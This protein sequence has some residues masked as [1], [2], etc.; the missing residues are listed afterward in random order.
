MRMFRKS[1]IVFSA[2]ASL[3]AMMA[4]AL[5]Q[6]GARREQGV[7]RA[8]ENQQDRIGQGVTSGQLT[9]GEAARLER[10]QASINRETNRLS[11]DGH[12]TRRDA[13]LIDRRQDRQSRAIYRLK[14]NRRHA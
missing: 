3:G 6:D 11:A 10:N 1:A 5:A 2:I 7:D 14:H 8:Q 12:F 13:R 4:P 9:A